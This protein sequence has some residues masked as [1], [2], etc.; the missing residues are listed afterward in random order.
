MTHQ[1]WYNQ[2]T[3]YASIRLS[4]S[5]ETSHLKTCY[6]NKI[7]AIL[8]KNQRHFTSRKI[9]YDCTSFCPSFLCFANIK[10]C[11]QPWFFE[12]NFL[13]YQKWWWRIHLLPL[14]LLLHCNSTTTKNINNDYCMWF[15]NETNKENDKTKCNLMPRIL[16]HCSLKEWIDNLL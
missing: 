14:L 1:V 2:I 12:I 9:A 3:F 5:L 4:L 16:D 11:I 10:Y 8:L 7:F 13:Y 15:C 6:S